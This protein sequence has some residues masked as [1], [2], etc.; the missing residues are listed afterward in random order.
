MVN[1]LEMLPDIAKGDGIIKVYGSHCIIIEN[2]KSIIE[3]NEKQVR[4]QGKK[5]RI[6][7]NGTNLDIAFYTEADMRIEG[8]IT[9][10]ILK[11]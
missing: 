5:N 4:I 10:V 1:R 11:E 6:T 3:Y 7:I 8:N 9:E 2:Y